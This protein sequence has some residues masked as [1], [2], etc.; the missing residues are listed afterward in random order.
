MQSLPLHA[1]LP[2]HDP[3]ADI[4]LCLFSVP[5]S[6]EPNGETTE[7]GLSWELIQTHGTTHSTITLGTTVP[8]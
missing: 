2:I 4:P 7:R 3:F 8:T 5:L 6:A 1:T